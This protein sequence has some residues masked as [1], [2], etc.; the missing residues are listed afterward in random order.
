MKKLPKQKLDIQ[1][2]NNLLREKKDLTDILKNPLPS[3]KKNTLLCSSDWQVLTAT[4]NSTPKIINGVNPNTVN[5]KFKITTDELDIDFEKILPYLKPCITIL[6]E[7]IDYKPTVSQSSAVV[8]YDDSNDGW[9]WSGTK[10]QTTKE[11]GPLMSEDDTESWLGNKFSVSKLNYIKNG[12]EYTYPIAW[13]IVVSSIV[14]LESSREFQVQNPDG[15]YSTVI[16]PIAIGPFVER[17]Y[18]HPNGFDLSSNEISGIGTRYYYEIPDF[19]YNYPEPMYADLK[20]EQ[21]SSLSFESLNDETLIV[22]KQKSIFNAVSVFVSVSSVVNF[23]KEEVETA[24]FITQVPEEPIYIGTHPGD[25]TILKTGSW[26]NEYTL[27]FVG[28]FLENEVWEVRLSES[29]F[30]DQTLP[31]GDIIYRWRFTPPVVTFDNI[32]ESEQNNNYPLNIQFV[33][34]EDKQELYISGQLPIKPIDM[35]FHSQVQD[36]GYIDYYYVNANQKRYDWWGDEEIIHD[37]YKKYVGAPKDIE[38]KCDIIYDK[39]ESN[40]NIQ[41]S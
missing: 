11:L 16:K 10:F 38:I 24:N 25:N 35:Q 29:Y 18:F 22:D 34:L 17:Y 21:I 27:L 26:G 40:T 41:L 37:L 23:S 33:Q 2:Q 3:L 12:Q 31:A 28:A 36:Q 19:W 7:E 14:Y 30:V 13:Y 39:D 8:T 1:K 5:F 6:N 20:T 4:P 15:T 9:F 32:E